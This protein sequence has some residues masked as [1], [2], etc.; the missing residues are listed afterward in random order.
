[1]GTYFIPEVYLVA[2]V[3]L[4]NEFLEATTEVLEE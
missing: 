4:A 2:I 3:R 1:M